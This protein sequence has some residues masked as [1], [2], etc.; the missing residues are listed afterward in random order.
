MKKLRPVLGVF[1]ML[2]LAAFDQ[3]TKYLVTQNLIPQEEVPV[4]GNFLVLH[5]L[6]NTGSAWSLLEGKQ[7]F[8]IL[9]S[10]AALIFLIY[11]YCRVLYRDGYRTARVCLVLII[12][13]TLGNLIDRIRL[14]YV[15][16]FLYLKAIHFPI[17]NVADLC[18][19]IP[20]IVLAAFYLFQKEEKE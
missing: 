6:E 7:T 4:F 14:H 11:L 13:G 10:I 20:L 12:G 5:R 8:L 19:T 9:V 15:V 16:D 18:I 2:L 17:F 1:F 3:F